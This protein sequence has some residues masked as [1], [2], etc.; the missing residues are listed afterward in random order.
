MRIARLEDDAWIG[1]QLGHTP[2]GAY[3]DAAGREWYVKAPAT[4]L[5]ARNELLA[6]RLYR[7]AGVLVPR[8]EL[9]DLAGRFGDDRPLGVRS[10]I[11]PGK[12]DLP[13][14]RTD[15][16]YMAKLRQGFAVDAWLANWDVMGFAL[17]N[18]RSTAKGPMRVD[19]GGALLFRAKGARKGNRFTER[20]GEFDTMRDRRR[21]SQC[22]QIYRDLTARELAVGL[23]RIERIT[24]TQIDQLVE[25]VAFPQR[26]DARLKATLKA[27]R[28]WLLDL[29]RDS[30][31]APE[32]FPAFVTGWRWWMLTD[33]SYLSGFHTP[34]ARVR[35][36][37]EGIDAIC[38]QGADDH[39]PYDAPHPTCEC[40]IRVMPRLA[41]LIDGLIDEPARTGITP[42]VFRRIG[43]P[44]YLLDRQMHRV[45][46]MPD[47]VG[48]VIGRGRIDA[49]CEW[50]DPAG[51]VRVEHARVGLR[52]YLS[53]HL[54]GAAP[55]LERRYSAHV[56]VSSKR[57]RDWLR[58]IRKH[59]PPD[60]PTS[61]RRKDTT[62][63][64]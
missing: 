26:E 13:E 3:K 37:R 64:R 30:V 34:H 14:R 25:A 38:N 12:D 41:D 51:T 24:G 42:A 40:G 32:S 21:N 28:A 27:R 16:P 10:R 61:N 56:Y 2:G 29:S 35:W 39:G 63:A 49:A 1:R 47:V 15:G 60:P 53:P 18:V 57:G 45:D 5:H 50:D 44:A 19:L 58:E 9:V 17:N 36:P 20:V 6:S 4:E 11:I 33:D 48:Q 22:A 7:A 59:A 31:P 46:R 23:S 43:S 52:L 62:D 55:L 54:V 8:L